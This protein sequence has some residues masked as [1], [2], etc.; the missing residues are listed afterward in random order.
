MTG[1]VATLAQYKVDTLF[2]AVQADMPEVLDAAEAAGMFLI[3]ENPSSANASRYAAILGY[4]VKPALETMLPQLLAGQ[5]GQTA[6]AKVVL[7][8]VN[9]PQKITPARQA[10]FA[11]TADLLAV[12]EIIPLSVP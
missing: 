10:L 8:S 2:L 3:G 1:D 11:G 9:N 6:V 5:G 7:V 4:D 12:D